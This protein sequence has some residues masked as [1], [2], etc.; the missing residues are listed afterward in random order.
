MGGGRRKE[1]WA[2]IENHLRSSEK[3]Q[4]DE[5]PIYSSEPI[6]F[7]GFRHSDASSLALLQ[8]RRQL[9][10]GNEAYIRDWWGSKMPFCQQ[11]WPNK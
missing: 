2:L 9:I 8:G 1:R 3:V 10:S 7:C 11:L 5:G 4:V 6:G